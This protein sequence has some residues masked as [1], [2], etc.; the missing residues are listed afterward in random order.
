[1]EN[2]LKGQLHSLYLTYSAINAQYQR[3]EAETARLQEE[4]KTVSEILDKTREQEKEIINKLEQ[5][6]GKKMTPNDILEIIKEYE[7][8]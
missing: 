6:L 8:L 5:E 1:M 7:Q 3:I 2:T 4:R